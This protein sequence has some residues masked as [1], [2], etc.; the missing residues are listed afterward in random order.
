MS[1]RGGGGSGR[2]SGRGGSATMSSGRTSSSPVRASGPPVRAYSP[3]GRKSVRTYNPPGRT[4]GPPHR[5]GYYGGGS[6]IYRGP[7]GPLGGVLGR[8]Y[9]GGVLPYG[10]RYYPILGILPIPYSV[11][12]GGVWSGCGYPGCPNRA[13]VQCPTCGRLYCEDHALIDPHMYALTADYQVASEHPSTESSKDEEDDEV[14]CSMD[15]CCFVCGSEASK[16]RCGKCKC[17]AYC[18]E[19]CQRND[20][21]NGHSHVCP[22]LAITL[23]SNVECRHT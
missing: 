4:S 3:T 19:G 8:G 22:A 21:E 20:W 12:F 11:G 16:Y 9:Y 18:S 23:S 10:R 17:V 1:G 5:G 6:S 14:G 2:S 7:R 13:A 15:P